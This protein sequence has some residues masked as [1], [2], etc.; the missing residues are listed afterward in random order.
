MS[1]YGGRCL[2]CGFSEDIEIQGMNFLQMD[3]IPGGHMRL[4]R[5]GQLPNGSSI[6]RW[7]KNHG[8]PKDF[9]ILCAACNV[10]MEPGQLVC[11]YHKRVK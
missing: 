11:E 3:F 1:A 5:L 8:F 2:C 6:Y 4:A 9:R 7:L 10:S